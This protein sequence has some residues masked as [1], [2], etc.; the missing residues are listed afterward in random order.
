[1][2]TVYR[3][4]VDSYEYDSDSAIFPANGTVTVRYRAADT[5]QTV[6]GETHTATALTLDLTTN[7]AE[8]IVPAST[9]FT[10]GGRTYFERADGLYHSL[11]AATGAATLGGSINRQSGVVT[12]TDWPSGQPNTLTLTALLTQISGQQVDE[13]TFRTPGAP[14]RPGSLSLRANQLDGTLVS[15]TAGNDGVILTSAMDGTVDVLTG[16]ARVRFGAWVTAAGN[17]AED[18]YWAEAIRAD[19]KIFKP[20]H[21]DPTTILYNCVV[22][23]YLP[24][25]ADI[26]GLD[27]VRLPIDGKVPVFQ[28]GDI[29]VIHQTSVTVCP[30]PVSA[31]Q[32]VNCGR[33]RIGRVELRDALDAVVDPALYT[34]DLDAG[35]VTFAT[36]LVLTAYTQPLSIR[37]AI[38]DMALATA[39]DID[40][41]I[42]LNRPL[43]HEF[44]SP[45][46]W[47]SSALLIGDLYAH[48]GPVF[49]QQ[50]W[51]GVW[52]DTRIGN[53]I[54]AQYNSAQY[55]IE[56]E[57]ASC[58]QQQWALIFTST[59]AFRV[60]GN[61]LGQVMTGNINED[62]A[63]INPNTG[64][65]YFT[66]RSLGLGGGWASGNVLRYP[67]FAA[68][69]P[70]NL[71]RT[72]LQSAD[73]SDSDRFALAIRGDIDRL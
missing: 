43:S 21:V 59:T 41:V 51:T 17:E 15:A 70:I 66:L 55:P 4:L 49:S 26:L 33:V 1:M 2:A 39:V 44:P 36:P 32:V 20:A 47:V 62:C 53:E 45:G 14:L 64:R 13:V 7:Y 60:V 65:P 37:H 40:G 46:S 71:A 52:S 18:W 8:A 56:V 25:S 73:S 9:R 63:P 30:N 10:L 57:N 50:T 5:P 38:E 48:V 3:T 29:V 19:G 54:I 72:I 22:Y 42:T 23:T 31:G 28:A 12:L 58:I 34:A 6:I 35:T 61:T 11:D 24:L 68:N 27:P 67:T 69:F 16:V